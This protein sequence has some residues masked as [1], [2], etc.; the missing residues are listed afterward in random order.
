MS[1]RFFRPCIGLA[2]LFQG[3]CI[4]YNARPLNPPV[5]ERQFRNRSLGDPGLAGFLR[6]EGGS[7]NPLDLRTLTLIAYYFSPDLDAARARLLAANAGTITARQ[8]INPSLSGD[9]GYSRNPESALTYGVI[10]SFTIET[11][12]KRGYRVLQAETIAEV[13]RL[14]LAQSAWLV[15]S[16][17]RTA[18]V[19][20]LFA[21]R[22][23][24]T[25]RAES[26]LRSEGV[27]IFQ[28]RLAVGE[29]SRP[30]VDIVLADLSATQ[31][32]LRFA[33][34]EV[35]QS[36]AAMAAAVGLPGSAL[37]NMPI[38]YNNIDHP[39]GEGDLPLLKVQRAGLLNRADVR[40]TLAE[41]AAADV[42]LRL[43]IAN[44]YPNIQLSPTYA[45]Q[46]GF[47][48]YTLGIGLNSLPVF[49]RH[50]GPIAQAEA[51]RKQV[52]TQFLALQSRAIGQIEE[53]LRQ[54]RAALA[55][56]NEAENN[57]LKVQRERELAARVAMAAGEG[58]RLAVNVARLLTTVAERTRLDALQRAQ[59]ALGSLEDAVQAPLEPG[60]QIPQPRAEMKP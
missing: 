50:R 55:K 1:Y 40:R 48:D 13:A 60:L 54:Y 35:S 43:E 20:N 58:D 52:E 19:A 47:V 25:V 46:E 56:R 5:A 32:A 15:R 18:L 39:P 9:A 26:A 12:G 7:S 23:L 51:Q 36:R 59:T 17:V 33:E 29:A 53:A 3:A 45:F 16:R 4:H 34:G 22:R 38:E 10:P 42:G 28:K 14:D 31:V 6:E 57:F 24:A 41:F 49:H 8:R 2:V 44:Q 27:E 11:A 21:Q 37:D 30:E